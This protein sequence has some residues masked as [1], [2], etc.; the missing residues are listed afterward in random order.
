MLVV[1]NGMGGVFG[2]GGAPTGLA[3][4]HRKGRASPVQRFRPAYNIDINDISVPVSFRNISK[5]RF[6]RDLTSLF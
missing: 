5:S 3:A 2:G 4:V 6:A 1:T